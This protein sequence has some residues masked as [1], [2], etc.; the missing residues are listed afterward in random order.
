[1]KKVL[2]VNQHKSCSRAQRASA[3]SASPLEPFVFCELAVGTQLTQS[4]GG[5]P[6]LWF[7]LCELAELAVWTQLTPGSAGEGGALFCGSNPLGSENVNS[8]LTGINHHS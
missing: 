1:M 6:L 8:I 2:S 3:E 4:Q 5:R 7:V